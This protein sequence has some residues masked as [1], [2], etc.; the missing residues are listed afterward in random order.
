MCYSDLMEAEA[1]YSLKVETSVADSE[2]W[3]SSM[4]VVV[5]LETGR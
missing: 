4:E 5:I 3:H 2:D 1:A